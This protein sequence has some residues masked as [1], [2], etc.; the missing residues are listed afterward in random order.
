MFRVKLLPGFLFWILLATA[1][2]A[3]ESSQQEIVWPA[4]GA[5]VV[6]FAFGKFKESPFAGKQRLFNVDATVT[7]VWN[8]SI[9]KADFLL[10]AF[11]KDKIRVGE[12][13]ISVS[14]LAPGE[15]SKFQ[16]PLLTAGTP[17]SL[18]VAP[19]T[20]PAELQSYL[21]AKMISITVNSVPQ[22]AAVKVDGKDVGTTPKIVQL[23]TGKH[24]LEFSKEG[25]NVGRF[26]LEIGPDD[27]SGGNVSYELGSSAHD[28]VEL[29]D[30]SLLT[31]DVESVSATEVVV[32]V[33]GT[34]QHLNRNEV[35]RILLV[36][37]ETQ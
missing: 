6:R 10:Y 4:S 21:P 13:A 28:T 14:N 18:S 23:S 15:V 17:V 33:G 24:F 34:L 8:K 11:D 35:K 7:N 31:G 22:G 32:R 37:R 1:A 3:K 30:G 9:S 19:Q 25:F 26:P 36:E 20:L 5:S 2:S 12:G 29:R 16:I 27:V